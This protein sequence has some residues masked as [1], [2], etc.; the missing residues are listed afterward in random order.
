MALPS[1]NGWALVPPPTQPVSV[2]VRG[3]EA[4]DAGVVC[5]NVT[6]EQS[7][8]IPQS[9]GVFIS[10]SS[11]PNRCKEIAIRQVEVIG[12][13]GSFA[14]DSHLRLAIVDL[15]VH[16]VER[17]HERLELGAVHLLEVAVDSVEVEIDAALFHALR[18]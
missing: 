17:L 18:R 5:A 4:L 14:A 9:T 13:P 8:A 3:V 7:N 15:D 6:D 2:T 16:V 11:R 10:I 1:V 12:A